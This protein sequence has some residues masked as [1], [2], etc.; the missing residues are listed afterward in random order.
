MAYQQ[1]TASTKGRFLKTAFAM[2][3]TDYRI[4]AGYIIAFILLLI[5]YLITFY[6]NRA[7]IKQTESVDHTNAVITNLSNLQSS[8]T[9][10]ETGIRGFLNSKDTAF[11][12]PFYGSILSSKM[13]FKAVQTE[14]A[15]DAGRQQQLILLD[16]FI[17]HKYQN[18]KVS[19]QH[20]IENNYTIDSIIARNT[21]QGKNIMDS[22]R[23]LIT[24]MKTSEKEL[25]EEK[26]QKVDSK[27]S[28]LNILV[29]TSLVLAFVFAGFGV[30]TFVKET[31]ERQKSDEK[32]IEYQQQLRQRIQELDKANRELIEI[33]RQEKFVSTGRI[34]RM[35]AHEVRN[36]LTNID[37]AL[38]QIKDEIKNESEDIHFLADIIKRNSLRINQLI[39]ELL[40]ATRIDDLN[41]SKNSFNELLDESLIL[42]KDRI[43]LGNIQVV[44]NYTTDQCDIAVD[45]EKIKIAFLNIIIN[46]IE[47]MKD[48][49]NPTLTLTTRV[50]NDKVKATIADNGIGM[51]ETALSKLFEAYYTTKQKGN[52]LG[53]TNTQNII[54]N[55]KGNIDVESEPGKG[56]NFIIAFE[57]AMEM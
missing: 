5:S 16:S 41:L 52:G 30:Y 23:Q 2:F 34:A 19:M 51:D 49:K 42:A 13:F 18:L 39:T 22:I 55:H 46:G 29:V 7:L 8:V 3:K 14:T 28:A 50:E 26:Y 56:T 38:T 36:P 31:K 35:I 54:L 10:A 15:N 9:D 53:L 17:N 11:L 27:Y 44:K 47:A 48:S 45:K 43:D 57:K 32:V 12:S 21:Y 20:F 37:L 4:I 1:Q 24:F 25:L 6:S 33:R 40:N